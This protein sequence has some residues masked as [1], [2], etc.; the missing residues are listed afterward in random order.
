MIGWLILGILIGI[1]AAAVGV[2][3]AMRKMMLVVHKSKF[4]FDETVEKL[5]TAVKDA[6]WSLVQSNRLN[7]NLSK[8]GIEFQPRVQLL[9]ICKAPYA[10]EVLTDSRHVSCLMPCTISVYEGDDETVFI[11]KMNTGL[12]GKVFGGTIARVMG[13][14][15][16]RDE[17]KFM[18]DVAE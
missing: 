3:I 1:A 5:E 17:E 6:E 4:G 9:K 7:D 2:V 11:S 8:H 16:S 18:R 10:A 14:Y 15:V 13:G 12:M